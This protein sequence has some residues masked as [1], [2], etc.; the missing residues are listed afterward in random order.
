M[1]EQLSEE[2]IV[3][4]EKVAATFTDDVL[5][6]EL[7]PGLVRIAFGEIRLDHRVS[8]VVRGSL[9]VAYLVMPN[10]TARHLA[11]ILATAIEQINTVTQ[12][13]IRM[14]FVPTRPASN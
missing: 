9:P 14:A 5:G 11:E 12:P 10:E 3:G 6:V 13:G 8:T 4:L 2:R 1:T 7:T